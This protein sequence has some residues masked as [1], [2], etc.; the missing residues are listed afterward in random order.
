M[1]TSN[2][3][4]ETGFFKNKENSYFLDSTNLLPL[5]G[6]FKFKIEDNTFAVT[7]LNMGIKQW[8][9]QKMSEQNLSA[10]WITDQN[11]VYR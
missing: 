9:Y 7:V 3:K 4:A 2:L 6:I 11:N 5:K 10:L 1:V 8:F